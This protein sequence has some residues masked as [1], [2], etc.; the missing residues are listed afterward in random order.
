M[1]YIEV[2]FN[3]AMDWIFADA[4]EAMD[5]FKELKELEGYITFKFIAD[6]EDEAH[7]ITDFAVAWSMEMDT[8]ITEENRIA[9]IFEDAF[10]EAPFASEC[11][12]LPD[13]M[14]MRRE[15][16]KLRSVLNRFD[17]DYD[18]FLEECVDRYDW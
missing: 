12:C 8:M 13:F 3:G 7:A 16:E 17:A 4:Y 2:R 18:A 5:T 9:D 15:A 14:D 1:K 6:S 11:T 10:H